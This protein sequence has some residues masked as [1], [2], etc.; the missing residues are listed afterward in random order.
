M[1][2]LKMNGKV[3]SILF[4]GGERG[5]CRARWEVKVNWDD[6]R[7]YICCDTWVDSM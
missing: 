7:S 1:Y 5:E 3:M 6:A 2:S 4:L